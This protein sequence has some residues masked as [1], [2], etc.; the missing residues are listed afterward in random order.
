VT[1]APDVRVVADAAAVHAEVAAF[2][3][4]RAGEAIA[5]RGRFLLALT[6]GTT[7]R[8]AYALLAGDPRFRDAFDWGAVEI[9]FG[10]ERCVPPDHPESNY[11]MAR[12]ALLAKVPIPASRVHRMLGEVEPGE[13]AARYE[14]ELRAIVPG[15][16]VPRLDLVLLGIGEDGHVASLFPGTQAFDERE[17]LVAANFVPRLASWR[18]TFSFP[19]LEAARAVLFLADGARKAAAVRAA[20]AR[21][22]APDERLPARLATPADGTVT[23]IV[24]RAAAGE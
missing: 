2:V 11:G 7:P 3:A 9:F 5:A 22:G 16:P 18:I 12:D 21:D 8:G 1:A 20:L 13:A 15:T 6:G 10:D 23:W 4:A 17:R 14:A 24:D 19:V